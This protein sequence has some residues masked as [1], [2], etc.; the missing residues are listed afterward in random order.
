MCQSGRCGVGEYLY[1]SEDSP[2]AV[3]PLITSQGDSL[4]NQLTHGVSWQGFAGNGVYDFNDDIELATRFE[5]FR[6]SAGVRTGLRQSL[7]EVTETLIYKVP[8]VTG[9]LARLECR[10]DASKAHP[11]YS[12]DPLIPQAGGAFLPSQTYTGQD[13][14]LAAAIYSF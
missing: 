12:N 10:H 2:V 11:F 8:Q 14:L 6:D 9:L 4:V 5:Y 7:F 1:A 3:S 13:T